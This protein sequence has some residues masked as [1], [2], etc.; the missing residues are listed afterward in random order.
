MGV[1][2]L[3]VNDLKEKLK[4]SKLTIVDFYADWCGPCKQ[5]GPILDE[6]SGEGSS[7]YEIYKV[8]VDED[9][10]KEFTSQ[11]M[12]M[13]LP[14]VLFFKDGKMIHNFIGLYDKESIRE[15]I[16]SHK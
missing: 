4:Q 10:F 13:S 11:H 9:E 16:E 14:T 1:E 7:D 6:L 15:M 3:A 12:I 8:N 5:L 2:Q